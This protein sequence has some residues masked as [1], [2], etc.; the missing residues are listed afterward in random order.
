LTI[1]AS[2]GVLWLSAANRSMGCAS[3]GEFC[4]VEQSAH[5]TGEGRL[6]QQRWNDPDE[7]EWIP[8]LS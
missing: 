5:R 6:A 1:V 3:C 4:V 2:A 8:P 7:H